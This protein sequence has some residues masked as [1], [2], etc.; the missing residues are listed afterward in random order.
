MSQSDLQT[1]TKLSKFMGGLAQAILD[2]QI[3][4]IAAMAVVVT[5]L[6]SGL[7][8]L[9]FDVSPE[10]FFLDGAPIVEDWYSFKDKY[11]SDEFSFVVVTPPQEAAAGVETI[12]QL[13]ATFA[14]LDGVERVTS[15]T[16]V[17]SISSD[18]D[19]IDVGE[20]LRDDLT[21]QQVSERLAA[22]PS[23]PY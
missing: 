21:D 18:G 7:L 1:K 15:L 16:N 6:S 14:D 12:R 5:I 20:Y 2:N 3:K 19:F 22:A 13:T 9:G 17:R 10:S 23:H 8:R 4:A 11:Q